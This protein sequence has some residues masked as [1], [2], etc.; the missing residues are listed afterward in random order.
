MKKRILPKIDAY[1]L[2]FDGV[3]LESTSLKTNAFYALY[4][5]FG[6][7]V[8]QKARAYH[9]AHEGVNRRAK[10]RE[11]HK[12]FLGKDL[13]PEEEERLVQEFSEYVRKEIQNCPFVPGVEA[14][15]QEQ[16]VAGTPL[17][18]LSATPEDDLQETLQARG[19]P[20]YFT[21]VY[22]DPWTKKDAGKKILAETGFSPQKILFVGDSLQDYEASQFLGTLFLGRVKKGAGVNFPQSVQTADD[23]LSLN[24]VL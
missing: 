11:I 24:S 23:F 10:F 1:F 8:A 14:F 9:L 3:V 15:L 6:E 4:L 7:T 5:P 2:D 21:A 20:P 18:L 17:F 13:M 19:L 12:L 16:R 22:G